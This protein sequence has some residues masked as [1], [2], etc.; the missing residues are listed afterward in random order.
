[1]AA[2]NDQ[3]ADFD[4]RRAAPRPG[5]VL[6]VVNPV[7]GRRDVSA[8]LRRLRRRLGEQGVEL[9]TATTSGAGDAG[10]LAREAPAGMA[11][12][13]AVGG[14]GTAREVV[15]ALAGTGRPAVVVPAGTENILARH[16]K[17]RATFDDVYAALTAG[18]RV[19][20]DVGFVNGRPFLI[21]VGAGFDA[22]V[23]A[24]LA[25][26]RRGHIG[27]LDYFW[28]LWQTFWCHRFPR[29][30]VEADGRCVFDDYGLVL[31]GVTPRYSLGLR[32]LRDARVDDGLLDVCAL[33]CRRRRRLVRHA[34][35]VLARRHVEREGVVYRQCRNLVISSPAEAPVEVDGDAGG[36]LPVEITITP[37]AVTL[38]TPA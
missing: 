22:E 28:P 34:A 10:R 11:A 27:Y 16:L 18:R 21:V 35:D 19:D 14:D 31:A 24:R 33:P 12:V 2:F 37:R 8:L 7:S 5:R 25:R 29:L 3:P 36:R 15:T 32:I 17:V 23:V 4:V 6:A 20:M 26:R 9:D 1:M 38:L 13:L 30:R